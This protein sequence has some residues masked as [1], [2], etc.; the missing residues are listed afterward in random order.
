MVRSTPPAGARRAFLLALAFSPLTVL[1]ALAHDGHD[2]GKA[3]AADATAPAAAGAV[4]AGNLTIEAP[5]L[6]ATPGGAKV[7]GGY[8]TVTN[9]GSVA[10]RLVGGRFPGAA[11][12]EVHEMALKDG[13]MT[14]RP[15]AGL[16][17]P[18]GGTVKLA[19]G[20]YHLMLMELAAPLV[21][22]T[23]VAGTLV[24]EKAGEVPVTF[25][26]RPIGAGGGQH[27]H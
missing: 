22:D 11:R 5:W 7:G 26:V 20:G 6:R 4:K 1:P 23:T 2:H 3:K 15:M 16:E 24:F 21:A 13:V 18:A 14:M 12:V 27:Q 8:L 19:P 9:A 25:A 17:I 10:D